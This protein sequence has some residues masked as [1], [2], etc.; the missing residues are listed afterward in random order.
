MYSKFRYNLTMKMALL[1]II[2]TLFLR[3]ISV[4]RAATC[5]LALIHTHTYTIY[6]DSPVSMAAACTRSLR[7]HFDV[8]SLFSSAHPKDPLPRRRCLVVAAVGAHHTHTHTTHLTKLRPLRL[9]IDLATQYFYWPRMPS[10]I[11]EGRRD[12]CSRLHR[13]VK[14]MSKRMNVGI[15]FSLI[16]FH[17]HR[18]GSLQSLVRSFDRIGLSMMRWNWSVLYTIP[19]QHIHDKFIVKVIAIICKQVIGRFPSKQNEFLKCLCDRFTVCRA[20]RF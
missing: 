12:L 7:T 2:Y 19:V 13:G 16:R 10:K 4:A 9:S 18:D 5:S 1:P 15:P 17:I 3:K 6:K 11:E 20:N 14:R 8:D